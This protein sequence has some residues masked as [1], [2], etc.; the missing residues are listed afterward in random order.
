MEIGPWARSR[1]RVQAGSEVRNTSPTRAPVSPCLAYCMASCDRSHSAFRVVGLSLQP[2]PSLD[3]FDEPGM[4]LQA[5]GTVVEWGVVSCLS[6]RSKEN[7]G[8]SRREKPTDKAG[9]M[10]QLVE[11]G[12]SQM[13]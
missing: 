2:P 9:Q 1:D 4:S 10:K 6:S 12:R 7:Q 8:S 11:K 13:G 5:A 3:R